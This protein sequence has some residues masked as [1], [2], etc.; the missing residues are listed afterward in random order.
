MYDS[1]GGARCL[2]LSAMGTK[3]LERGSQCA[4]CLKSAQLL[5]LVSL[6]KTFGGREQRASS[7]KF[8]YAN[9]TNR[10]TRNSCGRGP[11]HNPFLLAVFLSKKYIGCVTRRL[12]IAYAPLTH[13]VSQAWLPPNLT[14]PLRRADFS[15]RDSLAV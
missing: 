5:A 3:Q 15:L 13:R 4:L 12:K 9:L 1:L 6:E 14:Q 11:L 2:F 7:E 8:A 10:L